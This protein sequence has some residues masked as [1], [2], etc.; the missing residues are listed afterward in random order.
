ME[1]VKNIQVTVLWMIISVTELQKLHNLDFFSQFILIYKNIF[2]C[3]SD[4]HNTLTKT[5]HKKYNSI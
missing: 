2:S 1:S 4:S 3:A 5:I